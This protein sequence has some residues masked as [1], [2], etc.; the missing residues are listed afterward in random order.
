MAK[1]SARGCT[2]LAKFHSPKTRKESGNGF[3]T[4]HVAIR[5]DRWELRRW[6]FYKA[7]GKRDFSDGWKLYKRIKEGRVDKVIDLKAARLAEKGWKV[8]DFR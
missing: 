8:E 7:D 5:S 2:V 4:M 6:T 3:I 1:L